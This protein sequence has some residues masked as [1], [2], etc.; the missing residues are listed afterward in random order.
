MSKHER[1]VHSVSGVH[2]IAR[3]V[4]VAPIAFVAWRV[5]RTAANGCIASLTS[6]QLETK[7]ASTTNHAPKVFV[8]PRANLLV[9]HKGEH[10]VIQHIFNPIVLV[11]ARAPT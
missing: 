8:R 10:I 4:E 5:M 1:C 7:L 6:I 11:E 9:V 2:D 3:E